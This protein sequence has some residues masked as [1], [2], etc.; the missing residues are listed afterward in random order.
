MRLSLRVMLHGGY[1][2]L[3]VLGFTTMQQGGHHSRDVIAVVLRGLP[4]AVPVVLTGNRHDRGQDPVMLRLRV[5]SDRVKIIIV[6]GH[7]LK[8]HLPQCN[9]LAV[10]KEG[11]PW[12]RGDHPLCEILQRLQ[13]RILVERHWDGI[14]ST[15]SSHDGD[16]T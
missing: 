11:T 14:Q 7:Q 16:P 13:R 3:P 9:P 10:F 8:D 2:D 5:P 1:R 15:A 4:V 12:V 6:Q